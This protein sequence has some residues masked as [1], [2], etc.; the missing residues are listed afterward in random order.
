MDQVYI[1]KGVTGEW[2]DIYRWDVRAFLNL[3]EAETFLAELEEWVKKNNIN[4]TDGEEKY[5]IAENIPDCPLDPLFKESWS[6][7]SYVAYSI[8]KEVPL[9][10]PAAI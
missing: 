5:Q 2:E 10:P 6:P 8:G 9:G 3:E 1:V 7:Y 4:T